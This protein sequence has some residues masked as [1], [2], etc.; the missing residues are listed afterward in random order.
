MIALDDDWSGE[1]VVKGL[2]LFSPED[3]GKISTCCGHK[4]FFKK[5]TACME[6]QVWSAPEPV[7]LRPK[8]T[9]PEHVGYFTKYTKIQ[10]LWWK[11]NNIKLEVHHTHTLRRAQ[12]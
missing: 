10:C 1:T 7:H 8:I 2:A 4:A 5:E 11:K 6:E 3:L 12:Q 9:K